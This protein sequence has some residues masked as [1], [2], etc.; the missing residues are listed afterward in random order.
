VKGGGG[1][2][3][4][5]ERKGEGEDGGRL[6]AVCTRAHALASTQRP[7]FAMNKPVLHS[8]ENAVISRRLNS[9]PYCI[10]DYSYQSISTILRK[11]KSGIRID[12]TLCVRRSHDYL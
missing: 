9:T 6:H 12:V 10:S 5:G 4:A 2:A 11:M 7:L 1:R 8:H 3:R